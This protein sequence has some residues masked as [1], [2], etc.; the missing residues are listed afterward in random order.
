L[1][2]RRTTIGTAMALAAIAAILTVSGALVAT[3]KFSN[4]GT[5]NAV[6]VGVFSDAGCTI[7]TT[8]IAWGA[9]NPGASENVTI[10]IKNSGN[11]ALVLNMTVGNW[12]PATAAGNMTLTWNR[13]KYSLSA[14][15]VVQATLTLSV[16]PTATGITNFS[17]D[18]TITGT[19]P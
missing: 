15:T 2:M 6:G 8:S 12:N 14:A 18:I 7:P 4:T 19:G 11:A 9:L 5:V 17:F 16:S 10:Y 3:Q 13:E 1:A